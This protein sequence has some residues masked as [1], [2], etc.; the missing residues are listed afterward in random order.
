MARRAR[1]ATQVNVHE[2]K[3]TLSKLLERVEAGEE[4]VIAR[5]GSPVAKLTAIRSPRP[6]RVL[7]FLDGEFT[8]PDDFNRPLPAPVL[9][10]FEKQALG[11][12]SP[13]HALLP[14]AAAS[15]ER[16][17][18]EARALIEDPEN[19]VV[20]SAASFWEIAIKSALRRSST[21]TRSIACSLH[22]ASSS[23]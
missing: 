23:R 11:A 21:A 22:R 6:R 9:K 5:G 20:Y 19:D 4:I 10:D 8:I 17:P 7:G 13:R 2:A 14:W 16:L 1:K 18:A 12:S 15:G 3:T